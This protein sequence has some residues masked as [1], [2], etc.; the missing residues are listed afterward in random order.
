MSLQ[1][2]IERLNLLHE[3][4]DDSIDNVTAVAEEA[5]KR[6]YDAI[7]EFMNQFE[8]SDGRFVTSQN[9]IRRIALI[10]NKI[11]KILGDI[12]EPSITEYL[13]SFTSVEDTTLALQ[14]SYNDL[15][16]SLNL[17]A[18]SR[19]TIYDQAEYYL[20]QGL[21]DAY[22]QPAKYLL[23]QQVT[24]GISLA[25]SQRILKRWND[26]ELTGSLT[27]GRQTPNLQ[28][29]ATQ[30]SRDSLYQYYGAINEVIA[31]KYNLTAFI[32]TGDVIEDSR[33]MCR[34]L[35]GLKRE[36]EL[37]EM[38]ELIKKYPQGLYPNTDKENFIQLRG[39][40]NCRHGAFSVR[41]D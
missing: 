2:L 6:V 17:I 37:D 33:P 13:G 21:T 18:P 40:Y 28:K 4:M 14:K 20:I 38:P 5:Q 24:T 16:V 41:L 35:V 30:I 11:K 25:D 12:Y 9:Y 7:V 23:M 39:G 29:Y 34:H 26:G 3:L 15:E 36:I 32:Y 22:I 19:R 10:E 31:E 8:I 27:S 1:E